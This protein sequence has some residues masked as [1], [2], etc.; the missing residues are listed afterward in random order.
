[1]ATYVLHHSGYWYADAPQLK[2]YIKEKHPNAQFVT[3]IALK[4]R[5]GGFSEN[6]GVVL[7]QE[8]PPAPFTNKYF[9]YYKYLH[10][11]LAAYAMGAKGGGEG[12][13]WAVVGLPDW[14][15]VVSAIITPG[16]GGFEEGA[17]LT[18]SRY[19]HDY[20]DAPANYGVKAAIDGGREYA[21]ILGDPLPQLVKVNLLTREF[22]FNGE[23]CHV[24][25]ESW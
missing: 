15:P 19:G 1:M 24:E 2:A 9:A 25:P 20:V 6:P 14:D 12:A 17:I 13:E 4:T 16:P 11:K 22:E 5:A 21:R 3:E 23:V 10:P 8:N 7:Y 18:Y